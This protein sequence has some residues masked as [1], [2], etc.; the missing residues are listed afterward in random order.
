MGFVIPTNPSVFSLLLQ[1]AKRG[2]AN[3]SSECAGSLNNVV[4]DGFNG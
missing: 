2:S 4:Y 3:N 1:A